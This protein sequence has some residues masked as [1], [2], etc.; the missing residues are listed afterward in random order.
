M[1]D[2]NQGMFRQ[3]IRFL[4]RQLLQDGELPFSEV[5]SE[6]IIEKA[7]T[8]VSFVWNDRIYTPIVTLWVFLGQVMSADHSCRA[9]V[10]RFVAHRIANS[11]SPFSALTGA[12]CQARK[13]LPEKVISTVARLVGRQLANEAQNSWLWKGRHVN[14]F[15]GTT[16]SMPDTPE[17]QT[18]YPQVYNQKPGLGFPIA[19]VCTINSLSC[20]AV[21]DLGI[22][23]NAGK[24]QGEVSLLRQLWSVLS[25]GDI[26]RTDALLS[27]W[28]E[29]LTLK[30]RGIDSV[31]PL[32]RGNTNWNALGNAFRSEV[33]PGVTEVP[34]PSTLAV[35]MLLGMI[36]T[37]GVA[38]PATGRRGGSQP[39]RH[40][41]AAAD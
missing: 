36:V 16:A 19:R 10:A 17:N 20:G 7:R 24:R 3:Q 15:D 38:C 33:S 21:L 32:N 34:E 6:E 39:G 29:M 35:L 8:A 31:S 23:R 40:R 18:A 1:R 28:Y 37:A 30:Q 27:S 13:R 26:P 12:Y 25:P 14:M 4:R 22:C 11:R 2:C 5:R 9:A 41:A